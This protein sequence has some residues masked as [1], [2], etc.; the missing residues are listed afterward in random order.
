MTTLPDLHKKPLRILDAGGGLGQFS[1][2]LASQGEHE[3]L[4]IDISL[5]MLD[6][7]RGQAHEAGLQDRIRF[8]QMPLQ[9]LPL[10][11]EGPFDL[12]LF[13]GVIEWMEDQRESLEVL[14]KM[15]HPGGH[16]SLLFYNRD[17]LILKNG[18]NAHFKRI[19]TG[20]YVG[21]RK[22][23]I[24]TPTKPLRETEVRSWLGELGLSILSKGGIRI[25]FGLCNND[26]EFDRR[27]EHLKV[28]EWTYCRKEPFA[29]IA[30][31][32]HFVCKGKN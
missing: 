18:V 1:R 23:N 13:H 24:L 22:G 30:Q 3:I 2:Q 7:A 15:L 25:F 19:Q 31:H 8:R 29:S 12:I 14:K 9:E 27:I 26:Q 16:L 20:D 32:I 10:S 21:K 6:R 28:I 5:A 17:R 4:H 11:G